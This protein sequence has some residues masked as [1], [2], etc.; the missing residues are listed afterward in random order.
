MK[1]SERHATE[2][3]A[4]ARDPPERVRKLFRRV[5]SSATMMSN[6]QL[7]SSSSTSQGRDS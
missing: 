4:F 7:P 6:G 5:A 1:N 2:P 3:S